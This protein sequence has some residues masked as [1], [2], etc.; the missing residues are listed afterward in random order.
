[1]NNLILLFYAINS[2]VTINGD[3]KL[4]S[5]KVSISQLCKTEP[6]YQPN[7]P[8]GPYPLIINSYLDFRSVLDIDADKKTMT[9][10]IFMIME[11]IEPKMLLN[12]PDGI[13]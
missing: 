8:S 5:E 13:T 3:L 2:F 10:N 1:M 6:D 4:C 7:R 9:M 12:V 11:W